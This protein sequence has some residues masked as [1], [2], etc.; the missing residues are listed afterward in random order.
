[1]DVLMLTI[2]LCK[3][4]YSQNGNCHYYAIDD[5]WFRL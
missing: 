5:I 2:T 1:M 4:K 3:I